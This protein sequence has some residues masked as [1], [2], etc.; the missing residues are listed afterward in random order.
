MLPV[1]RARILGARRRRQRHDARAP[2]DAPPKRRYYRA[3]QVVRVEQEPKRR[4]WL[5]RLWQE[6]SWQVA[7]AA[8]ALES[9]QAQD[10]SVELRPSE[11]SAEAGP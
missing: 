2:V 4:R 1:S 5:G 3:S 6:V 7:A 9:Q 8:A 11:D 10:T